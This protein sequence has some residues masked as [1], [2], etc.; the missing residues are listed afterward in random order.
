MLSEHDL[1]S[2]L[3]FESQHPVLSVY[4]SAD[5]TEKGVEPM[6]RRL[7]ALLREIDGRAEPEVE[8]VERYFEH[9]FSGSGRSVAAFC[10]APADF[11]RAFTFQIPIRSRI[12]LMPRPYLKPLADLLDAYGGYGVALVNRQEVRLFHFHLGELIDRQDAPGEEVHPTKRGGASSGPGRKEGRAGQTRREG[13]LTLRNMRGFAEAAGEFFQKGHVRRI[14]LAGTE[15]NLSLFRGFLS[16]SWQSLVVG[17]F[18]ASM[19]TR[20]TEVLAKALEVGAQAERDRE[21]RLVETAVTAAAKGKGGAVGLD[22]TLAALH[23]GRVQVLLVS[24]GY[25]ETGFECS[26]CGFHT[27]QAVRVCPFCG[28]SFCPIEDAVEHAVQTTMLG[29]G[30]VEIIRDNPELEGAGRIAAILRY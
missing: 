7:R 20:P 18:A 17:T 5:P 10:C 23:E 2:L 29:E 6:R 27:A 15:D 21:A 28:N 11:F 1:K 9:A 14:L 19:G 30:E 4:V 13:E 25:R 24:E 3:E 12:R 26:G 8:A 22:D 16:K